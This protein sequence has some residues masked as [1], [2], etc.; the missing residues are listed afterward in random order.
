[1]LKRYMCALVF[2]PRRAE[3][4]CVSDAEDVRHAVALVRGGK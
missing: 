3:P 4:E 2:F 1:M